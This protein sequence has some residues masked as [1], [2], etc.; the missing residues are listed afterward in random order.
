MLNLL[1][2]LPQSILQSAIKGAVRNAYVRP[3][4]CLAVETLCLRPT[5]DFSPGCLHSPWQ[6]AAWCT[7]MHLDGIVLFCCLWFLD[8]SY[9][10][11]YCGLPLLSLDNILLFLNFCSLSF[12]SSESLDFCT[13]SSCSSATV[14]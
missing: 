8:T 14:E 11:F 4:I 12:S 2:R 13:C 1:K 3:R 5:R 6:I 7:A 10:T 9:S